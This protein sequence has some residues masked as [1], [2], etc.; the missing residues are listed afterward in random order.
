MPLGFSMLDETGFYAPS[1]AHNALPSHPWLGISG[2]HGH[3]STASKLLRYSRPRGCDVPT[4]T[5]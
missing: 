5:L 2:F 1:M 3:N 4:R